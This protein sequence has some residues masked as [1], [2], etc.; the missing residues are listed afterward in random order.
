MDDPKSTPND[1]KFLLWE[2]MMNK[3]YW[4]E[5][6]ELK[7]KTLVWY[8]K[9]VK[10]WLTQLTDLEENQIKSEYKKSKIWRN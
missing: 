6:P 3:E 2:K 8:N 10:S 4:T 7:I 1:L 5:Y 9:Y